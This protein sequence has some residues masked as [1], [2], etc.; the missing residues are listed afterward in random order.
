MLA[1]KPAL[2]RW[3]GFDGLQYRMLSLDPGIHDEDSDP[4]PFGAPYFL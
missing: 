2:A 1:L 4:S 3:R